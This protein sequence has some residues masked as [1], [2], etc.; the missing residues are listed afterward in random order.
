M[1]PEQADRLDRM[2]D[3]LEAARG[4]QRREKAF[5]RSPVTAPTRVD[6]KEARRMYSDALEELRKRG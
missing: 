6:P 1:Q 2:R 5:L 3:A 4:A